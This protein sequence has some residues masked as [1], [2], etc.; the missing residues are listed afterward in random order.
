MRI[1][2][3]A[4]SKSPYRLSI[5]ES[6]KSQTVRFSNL[7]HMKNN[8]NGLIGDEAYI[9][10]QG[11]TLLKVRDRPF[12]LRVLVQKNKNGDWSV[13]GIG[14]RLAGEDSITTHVPRGGS[15]EDPRKLLSASFNPAVTRAIMKRTANTAVTIAKQIE[16]GSGYA[17]GEMS[18]DLGIDVH[19]HLW[20]FEANSKPMKF[21]EAN[22]REKSLKTMLE[23]C[24]FLTSKR[25]RKMTRGGTIAR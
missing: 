18:M 8:L 10:Q 7:Q 3:R 24:I 25:K 14:A 17:L 22:I 2:R 13:T 11:I 1:R 23:Y 16:K 12:D 15:I 20:F 6:K 9:I 4:V 5:Q 21:D 19:G